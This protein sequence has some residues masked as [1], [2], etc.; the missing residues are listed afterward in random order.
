MNKLEII[1][2]VG[3]DLE[4]AKAIHQWLNEGTD[5]QPAAQT[6]ATPDGISIHT[7][8]NGEK[9]VR[10]K[11]LGE[12]FLIAAHDYKEG[13]IDEFKWQYAMDAMAKIGRAMWTKKQ[14]N[15]VTAYKDEINAK[16]KEIGGDELKGSYW[17]STDYSSS[18]AWSVYFSDGDI[19]LNYRC[20]SL[21]VRP[22]A[23][24]IKH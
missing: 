3:F 21:A 14:M 12:D 20:S 24:L 13:E 22:C 2:K 7:G 9:W 1:E 11:I 16:L 5:A 4:K 8:E 19:Y 18:Y 17:S 23:A 10:V 6:A 15:L